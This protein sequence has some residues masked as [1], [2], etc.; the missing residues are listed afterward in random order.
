ME[1]LAVKY[2]PQTFDDVVEQNVVKRILENQIKSNGIRNGYLFSGPSGCGKTTNA[3]LFAKDINGK[4]GTITELDAASHNGVDDIRKLIEDSKFKPIGCKYRVYIIDECHVLSSQAWQA[5]LKT[6]EEPTP[7]SIFILCTT[8]PQKIPPTIISRVQQ[9]NF[10]K[11]SYNGIVNRLKYIADSENSENAGITY[12]EDALLYIA[13][14]ADGGM[15]TAITF[16]EKVI[17]F[18]KAVNIESVVS[19]L[20]TVNYTTMFDLLDAVCKMNKVSVIQ[21]IEALNSNGV[22]LK[23]FIRDYSDFILDMCKYNLFDDFSYIQI[24]S[25]FS[26][27]MNYSKD[28]YMFFTQLLDEMM[29]LTANI[30]WDSSPKAL[31]ESTFILLCTEA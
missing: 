21:I 9:F 19:A 1:T 16:F 24:P 23:Q 31:I 6:L 11:I 18:S 13:K 22:D 14:L 2:R 29:K 12:D 25:T 28:E 8:D 7:T 26:D 30:K 3:R 17:G 27:R 20:G 10:Q 4:S 5:L 15:R